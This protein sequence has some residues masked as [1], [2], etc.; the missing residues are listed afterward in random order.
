M[1]AKDTVI[2]DFS[3]LLDK[4]NQIDM[5]AMAQGMDRPSLEEMLSDL[6]SKQAEI[7]FKAGYAQRKAEE[8]PY[9]AK[10]RKVGIKEV[11]DFCEEHQMPDKPSSNPYPGLIV[12]SKEQWRDQLEKWGIKQ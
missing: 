6:V 9:Y 10:E 1:E 2:T 12:I 7:T 11:V 8:L 3:K 5:A 4:Y